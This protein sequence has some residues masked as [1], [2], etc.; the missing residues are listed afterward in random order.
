MKKKIAL[1]LFAML[2]LAIAP[3]TYAGRF[4]KT[5]DVYWGVAL[6]AG[7]LANGR[8]YLNPTTGYFDHDAGKWVD[9]LD[10]P[11]APMFPDLVVDC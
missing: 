11:L 3:H 4:E 2:L 10:N 8:V 9:G 5:G 6:H 1:I 7:G